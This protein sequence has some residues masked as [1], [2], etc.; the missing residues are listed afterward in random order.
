MAGSRR[1]FLA[2]AAGGLACAL[3]GTWLHGVSAAPDAERSA[4]GRGRRPRYLVL[5]QLS[6]GPD[7]ILTL[8]PKGPSEVES[9]VD[10]PLAND[11]V[12][13]GAIRLGA[14][15]APL[16]KWA[17]RMA[18]VH[19][20]RVESVNHPAGSWQLTRMRRRVVQTVP[21]ILDI[22]ARHRSGQPLGPLT[23]GDLSDRSYTPGWVVDGFPAIPGQPPVAQGLRAFE[24]M[25]PADVA[26]L[27]RAM[28][29]HAGAPGLRPA[30]RDGYN[31]VAG[32]LERLPKASK[33]VAEDW[34]PKASSA[35]SSLQLSPFAAAEDG[36]QRVLW[37]LENDLIPGAM[38]MV[39]RN[40][41]DSH[42]NNLRKQARCNE[43]FVQLFDRFLQ[44]LHARRNAHGLLA[45]TTTVVVSGELGRYPRLNSD[46]GKDHYPEM[47]MLFMGAGIDAGTGGRLI[48]QTGKDMLA[49][50]IDNATGKLGG[51]RHLLLDDIGTTLLRLFGIEPTRYGY[52]GRPLEPLLA[53]VG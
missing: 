32:L 3:A 44:G 17:S 26:L 33:F 23:V 39:T 4:Q 53:A 18:V 7:A 12:T 11:G 50:P 25:D 8:D 41:W 46:Q 35:G 10:N 22:I 48:G 51:A 24:S 19:G 2:G 36:L 38:V 1:R 40:E 43:A 20:V 15:F 13:A 52:F 31:Q 28:R 34:K 5:I 6:G 47:P 21:G 29:E 30:D 27:A 14:Q 9:W 42:T 45:D 49:A 37:A 16:A